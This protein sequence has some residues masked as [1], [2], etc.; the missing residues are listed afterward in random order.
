[1]CEINSDP[2]FL[3][4]S[5]LFIELSKK[6]YNAFLNNYIDVYLYLVHG[7]TERKT[8]LNTLNHLVH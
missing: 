2:S 3:S 1:M 4:L 8:S 7:E 6:H 5:I